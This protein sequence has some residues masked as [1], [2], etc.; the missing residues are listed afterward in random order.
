MAHQNDLANIT[1]RKLN[2]LVRHDTGQFC[3][4]CDLVEG[5]R[6]IRCKRFPDEHHCLTLAD[7]AAAPARMRELCRCGRAAV[8]ME[9]AALQTGLAAQM[10]IQDSVS[11]ETRPARVGPD[12]D[13]TL[14]ADAVAER[15]CKTRR[16][17]FRHA[18]NLP[19]I[20]RI[21]RKT[22]LASESGLNLWIAKQRAA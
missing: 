5:L 4:L 10:S 17:V 13:F 11:T 22:L 15:L 19:F 8:A 1:Q 18:K 9:I 16:W 6:G 12:A 3:R 20:R 14:N 2:E 21:S 7:L